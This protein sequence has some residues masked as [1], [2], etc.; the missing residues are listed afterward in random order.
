MLGGSDRKTL[1]IVAREW[2]GPASMAA[3]ER[4]GHVLTVKVSTPGA[5]WP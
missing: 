1:F 5:G 3:P 2:R 4:T